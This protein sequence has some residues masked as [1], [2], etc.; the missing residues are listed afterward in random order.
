MGDGQR[1]PLGSLARRMLQEFWYSMVCWFRLFPLARPFRA[2]FAQDA[3]PPVLLLH[4]YGANSGFWKPMSQQL[5]AA[6]ITHAA[7]DLEPLLGSIDDYAELIQTAAQELCVSHGAQTIVIVGHSMGGLAAR[8]WLRRYGDERLAGLITLGTPHFGSTL[9][10]YAMGENARQ[11]LPAVGKEAS[12][13]DW[14]TSLANSESADL[15]ARMRSIYSRHDNIVAPQ[16]SALLPG[17]SNMPLDLVGHVALGFD[18]DV[19]QLLMTAI[20][21][22]RQSRCAN[23]AIGAGALD[24]LTHQFVEVHQTTD[25]AGVVEQRFAQTGI[26]GRQGG[27]AALHANFQRPLQYPFELVYG[28]AIR[29]QAAHKSEGVFEQADHGGGGQRFFGRKVLVEAGFGNANLS[30]HF[31]HR[32]Q[33]KTFFREQVVRRINDGVLANDQLLLFER[34]LGFF[35]HRLRFRLCSF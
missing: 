26:F 7:I 11:M 28:R 1:A 19:I 5:S 34:E 21:T 18:R 27:Q 29:G 9:A 3:L 2:H 4:G 14:L 16:Q 23:L 22:A 20:T 32:H 10:A 17:A 13:G 24:E 8:A 30:G 12:A 6:G 33:V 15:R 35:T 25:I 31:V